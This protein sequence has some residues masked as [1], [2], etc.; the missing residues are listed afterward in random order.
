MSDRRVG[1]HKMQQLIHVVMLTMCL[2]S[3]HLVPFK[4][5]VTLVT[6]L[7]YFDPLEEECKYGQTHKQLQVN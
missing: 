6:S 1:S 3:T 7:I 4:S 5:C 2:M